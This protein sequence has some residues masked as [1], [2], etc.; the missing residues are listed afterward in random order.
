MKEEI[1]MKMKT[2]SLLVFACLFATV[3][4]AETDKTVILRIASFSQV[5]DP[6]GPTERAIAEKFQKQNPGIKIEWIGVPSNEGTKKLIAWA[7]ADDLPDITMINSSAY[8]LFHDMGI[9]RD[10]NKLLPAEF[11][12]DFYPTILEEASVDG[13]LMVLPYQSMPVGILYRTDWLEETGLPTP[14]TWDDF[15]KVAKAMTKDTNG[16]GKIDRWGF[17]MLATRDDSAESR[18]SYI[19]D[20]FG[21]NLIFRDKNGQWQSGINTPQFKEALK[22]FTDFSLKDGITPPG[23]LETSYSE[24]ANLIVAGKAGMIL[25][26]SNAIGTILKQ[27]P[28][29]K[30]KLGSFI[31]PK[32]LQHTSASRS[33]GF[34]ITTACKNIDAAVAY[35]RFICENENLLTWNTATGRAPTKH[36]VEKAP[37]LN[38]KEM[39]GFI[40]G[41][42][43]IWPTQAFAG[44]SELYDVIGQAYQSILAGNATVDQAA[45]LASK[46]AAEVLASYQTKSTK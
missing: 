12:S 9:I 27:N 43:Y 10:L 13:Q 38:T 41:M 17:A 8:T 20:T 14:E 3:L 30:G 2:V 22:L 32:A 1:R 44:T 34:G 4:Y 24:A 28:S 45:A 26:G 37:Q 29:L 42:Q 33:L 18:F 7:A 35:L 39:A 25:T 36:S 40:K 19:M 46:R 6:E 23:V 21:I 16:D 11:L 31:V 15:R 5:E